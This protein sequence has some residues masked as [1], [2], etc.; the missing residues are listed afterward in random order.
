MEDKMLVYGGSWI[1]HWYYLI[2][3]SCFHSPLRPYV[4]EGVRLILITLYNG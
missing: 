1:E 2:E 4:N 3:D